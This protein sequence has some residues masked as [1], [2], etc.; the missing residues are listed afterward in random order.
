MVWDMFY[1]KIQPTIWCVV[2]CVCVCVHIIWQIMSKKKSKLKKMSVS[3]IGLGWFSCTKMRQAQ[4]RLGFGSSHRV[5]YPRICGPPILSPIA[6]VTAYDILMTNKKRGFLNRAWEVGVSSPVLPFAF[7][8]P[9]FSPLHLAPRGSSWR[10]KVGES[11][12][13]LWS[14]NGS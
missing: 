9:L 7:G 5:N 13:W 6:I 10:N 8:V 3:T 4:P 12:N 11:Q 14:L 2:K 1:S